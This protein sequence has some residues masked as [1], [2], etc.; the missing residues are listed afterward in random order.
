[1]GLILAVTSWK[2]PAESTKDSTKFTIH[3]GGRPDIFGA[4]P[5]RTTLRQPA[6]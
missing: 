2:E 1:M 3:P 6:T 5:S 4:D